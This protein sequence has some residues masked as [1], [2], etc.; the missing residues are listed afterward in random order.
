M[1][2]YIDWLVGNMRLG[3]SLQDLVGNLSR[4]GFGNALA[5]K[6]VWQQK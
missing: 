4:Y 2:L 5:L 1:G 3:L 6:L